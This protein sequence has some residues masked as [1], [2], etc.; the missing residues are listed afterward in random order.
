MFETTFS[1]ENFTQAGIS[2]PIRV[3]SKTDAAILRDRVQAARKTGD[4][5]ES[6]LRKNTHLAFPFLF[7]LAMSQPVL[8]AVEQVIGPD[9]LVWS[10]GFFIKDAGDGAFVSWHQDSTYW[11]L[12]PPDI[13]T[14]WIALTPS[15]VQSGCLKVVPGS[16][17]MEQL[18]HADTF[19]D[20][21]LLSRGQ[22][23]AIDVSQMQTADVELQPGEMS[24]HHVM[25]VHGSDANRSD[26]P[27]LGYAIRFIPTH[28]RQLGGRTFAVLAR[29]KDRY[30]HFDL[31]GKPDSEMSPKA[32]ALADEADLR[33][34]QIVM[35]SVGDT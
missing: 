11:G 20:G 14:A 8:D 19:G 17:L 18:P 6:C 29:G 9:I 2:T 33:I 4:R 34:A 13:V 10:S 28:V 12:E 32:L 24:L 22:E 27:R 21:N 25:L 3:L 31:V 16:H 7:D 1:L 5:A 30:G 15:T 26:W 35:P 23:V